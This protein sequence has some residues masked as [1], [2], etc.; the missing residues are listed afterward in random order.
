MSFRDKSRN[1]V[2]VLGATSLSVIIIVINLAF[3]V[4][5]IVYH[6]FVWWGELYRY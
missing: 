2:T 4:A 6:N 1:E 5:A 3:P